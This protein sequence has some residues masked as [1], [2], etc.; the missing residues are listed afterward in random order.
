MKEPILYI[1]I[2]EVREGKL[3][4][5]ETAIDELIAFIKEK[6]PR[7]IFYSVYLS[8]NRRYMTVV[9]MHPDTESL[10]YHIEV[11]TPAFSKFRGL[12][13]LNSIDLYGKPSEN[14]L[15]QLNRKAK[16]LGTN[17]T[18]TIHELREGIY[19]F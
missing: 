2:S 8:E 3:S 11:G 10:E 12:L 6:V 1:D 17:C 4:E 5:L 9:Q 7:L 18:L 14:L 16:L 13:Q 19:K 15:L